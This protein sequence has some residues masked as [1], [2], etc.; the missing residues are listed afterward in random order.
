MAMDNEQICDHLNDLLQLE[1]DAV[2]AYTTA[3]NHVESESIQDRLMEFRAD[4][5]HH[6]A[7]L[8]ERIRALGGKP[9]AKP[10]IKG[11]FLKGLTGIMSRMGDEN[12]L[13]VMHQNE[14]LTN[15]AYDKAVSES[16]PQDIRELLL[17][18]QS[19]ERRHRAW[20]EERL[21]SFKEEGRG[22][23]AGGERPGT[24]P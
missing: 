13:R 14:N 3:I 11:V 21:Q 18:C 19:D 9:K 5:N 7:R 1:F 12:A 15:K 17:T 23:E 20:I 16:Y 4:H 22:A 24:Q 6:V 10:D 8:S 2:H